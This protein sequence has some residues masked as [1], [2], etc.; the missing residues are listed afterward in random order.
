MY[1]IGNVRIVLIP[2]APQDWMGV[3]VRLVVRY[4]RNGCL[5]NFSKGCNFQIIMQYLCQ[6][7]VVDV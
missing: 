2:S 7:S 6:H 4:C 3:S 5:R 1:D